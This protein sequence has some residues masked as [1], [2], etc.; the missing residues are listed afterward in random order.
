MKFYILIIITVLF[1]SCFNK[2][3]SINPKS[4]SVDQLISI[5]QELMLKNRIPNCDSA[6]VYMKNIIE[7]LRAIPAKD[8]LYP[9]EKQ[10]FIIIPGENNSMYRDNRHLFY[11]N[12]DCFMNKPFDEVVNIF[13]PAHSKKDFEEINRK[14][15]EKGIKW[16]LSVHGHNGFGLGFWFE[17]GMVISASIDKGDVRQ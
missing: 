10:V 3:V 12:P 2:K 17:K 14:Y 16:F 7:P 13:C 9:V 11:I 6:K 1:G 4:N 15:Q 5:P 8:L